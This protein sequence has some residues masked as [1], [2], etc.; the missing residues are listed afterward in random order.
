MAYKIIRAKSNTYTSGREITAVLDTADDLYSLQV[1]ESGMSPGSIAIVADA[2]LT[3]YVLNASGEWKS[4]DEDDG[5]SGGGGANPNVVETYTG[6]VAT[7][8]ASNDIDGYSLA[9]ELDAFQNATAVLSIDASSLNFGIIAVPCTSVDFTSAE[10]DTMLS[11]S[12]ADLS[13]SY[14]VTLAYTTDVTTQDAE[15]DPYPLLAQAQMLTPATEGQI[16][17]ARD[18]VR[19]LP[20]TLTI[21]RHP[22][23]GTLE[24]AEGRTY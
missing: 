22:L 15:P 9:V 2:G 18:T 20:A 1:N 11:F 14:A 8:F 23:T 19:D 13:T 4:T 21:I 10:S 16:V 12:L 24:A 6:T 5:S 3:S 7:I 17:D